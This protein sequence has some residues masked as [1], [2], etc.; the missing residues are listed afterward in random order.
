MAFPRNLLN[1]N[2]ELVLDL[3]PHWFYMFEPTISLIG[4]VLLGF[5]V[6]L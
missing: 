1:D 3:N 4:A 5:I 6:L 2:E